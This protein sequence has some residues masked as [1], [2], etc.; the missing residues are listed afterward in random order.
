MPRA[1]VKDFIRKHNGSTIKGRIIKVN[2]AKNQNTDEKAS[3]TL[4][5]R[6]LSKSMKEEDLK[7]FFPGCRSLRRPREKKGSQF[8]EY[9]ES[10]RQRRDSVSVAPLI[11]L[12]GND[13]HSALGILVS[14]LEQIKCYFFLLKKG[15][16]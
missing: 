1:D 16:K 7:P 12:S 11:T 10:I 5:V 3:N 9:V 13:S 2:E 6:N 14:S 4:M 8:K 15:Y